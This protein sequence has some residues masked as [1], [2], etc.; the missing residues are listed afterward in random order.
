MQIL[1]I[2]TCRTVFFAN[3]TQELEQPVKPTI[4]VVAETN[5]LAAVFTWVLNRTTYQGPTFKV[6]VVNGFNKT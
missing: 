6:A 2:V 3:T 5:Q 4:T 1:P